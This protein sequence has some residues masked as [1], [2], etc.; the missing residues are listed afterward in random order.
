MSNE[1]GGGAINF[2]RLV[3]DWARDTVELDGCLVD[4]TVSEATLLREL[5]NR[6]GQAVSRDVLMTAIWHSEWHADTSALQVLVSRLRTK[7]GE[8][9]SAPGF[10]RTVHGR[11]YRFIH[12]SYLTSDSVGNH[13]AHLRGGV[14][15]YVVTDRDYV[16]RWID[17]RVSEIL[18]WCPGDL[19]GVRHVDLVH[20][21][22][23]PAF[24]EAR[25]TLVDS[26]TVAVVVPMRR[27]DS[28]YV[29]VESTVWRIMEGMGQ[30]P[31]HIA[32]WR[33]FIYTDIELASVTDP[34]PVPRSHVG[35]EITL[36]YNK[37]LILTS[38]S[39][40][41]TLFGWEGD[42]LVGT[43]FSPTGADTSTIREVVE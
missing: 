36:T 1:P 12:P 16:I 39:P 22:F 7:L 28:Q 33:P 35:R 30:P 9:A 29:M 25:Q 23:L 40:H 2:G 15:G 18:L 24:E 8:S 10:I 32:Q 38:I 34:A 43:S 17:D 5:T 31:V 37:D 21:D 41:G 26:G 4:L 11:G 42:Q 6:A 13:P 27:A 14:E 3:V 20:S 19:G